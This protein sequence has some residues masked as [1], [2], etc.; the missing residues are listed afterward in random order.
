MSEKRAVSTNPGKSLPQGIAAATKFNPHLWSA[1]EL[2]AIFV[3]RQRELES[4]LKNVR[5]A[6]ANTPPQHMLITGQ[7]GMGKSTLLQRVALAVEDDAELAKIWLPLRFPEEQYTVSTPA[8]LWSNVIGALADALER[9][10]LP[11]AAIDAELVALEKLPVAQREAAS[12]AWL[13]TWCKDQQRRLLLLVDS[14][15][16]LFAN[17][18]SGE[19]NRSG[20]RADG[21][22]SALWRVRKELLHAPHLFW[23]GGSYQPLEAHGLYNDAFL[24]FFQLIE[25]RPLTLLEMQRAILAMAQVFGAGRGLQGE[26]AKAQVQ[27]LLIARPE[28]LRAM[29]HL[30]GGNPR[31]TIMLYELFAAG[32]QDNVRSDLE[33]LLDVMTPL[34]KARLEILADQ[35]RKVLAHVMEHWAPMSAK[36]LVQAAGLPQGTI[37][38]QLNRL[39]Q[40]GLID[41]TP[42]S[43]TKRWGYQCSERF[44]NI[45]Y[46]MRNASRGARARVGWLVEFMRLWYSDVELQGLA[47]GRWDEHKKGL[48]CNPFELEYSRAIAYA[49]PGQTPHRRQLEWRVFRQARTVPQFGEL[50][51]LAG[52]DQEYLGADDYLRRFDA[53]DQPLRKAPIPANQLDAWVKEVKSSLFHSLDEKEEIAQRCGAMD[54]D[55]VAA[56]RETLAKRKNN[57]VDDFGMEIVDQVEAEVAQGSFFPDCPEAK[58]ALTQIEDCFET[59]PEAFVLANS[60]MIKSYFASGKKHDVYA[61]LA[62]KKAIDLAPKNAN[63]WIRYGWVLEADID[64]H[65]E[66]ESAFRTAIRLDP[67][68]DFAWVHLGMLLEST[69][70]RLSDAEAA[71]R[72]AL[73]LDSENSFAWGQLTSLLSEQPTRWHDAEKALRDAI[74]A[75]PDATYFR[76]LLGDLLSEKLKR[77]DDAERAYRSALAADESHVDS[78]QQLAKLLVKQGRRDEATMLYS[79]LITAADEVGDA[80]QLQAHLWLGH[81]DLALEALDNLSR[82]ASADDR[83][84]FYE[85]RSQCRECHA[86][87]L[88]ANFVALMQRSQFSGF[89]QPFALAL[90]AA[91]G[92]HGALLDVAVEVRAMAE[93]VLQYI[94]QQSPER[95][96]E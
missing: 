43:G 31:T 21:G 22:A 10:D 69:R 77:F 96:N 54:V 64:R 62:C 13:N 49:M 20:R 39:E 7:R 40:E 15:D 44:F 8:E 18:A 36:Q 37:S 72:N 78:L 30:T 26:A 70:D 45:W 38:A 6:D 89:L 29:R 81:D 71:Y 75:L 86:I 42:L 92:E 59:A 23:L 51:E 5:A 16:L 17:L 11:T 88:S 33:R 35:P 66:A 91:N 32:G 94:K 76:T 79:Q 52:A 25:L 9:Q 73:A 24:D 83:L 53:L 1:E 48:L 74:N 90:R 2:R 56:I 95:E 65:A 41:K 4:I 68:Q 50:F 67:K 93:E 63:A 34:Y 55:G 60:L 57:L 3:V 47:R 84:A 12:I 19:A 28:R 87:G 85:L 14:T 27:R 80:A 61:E 46:L 58:L 82:T